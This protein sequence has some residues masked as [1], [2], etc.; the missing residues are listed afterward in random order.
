MVITRTPLR[1]SFVGGGTDLPDYYR[2]AGGAVLN[3]TIDQYLYVTVKTHSPLFEEGIRLNYSE[4]ER[5]ERVDQLKHP[6]AREILRLFEMTRN[7]Y[8]STVADLPGSS[9]LG[10]SSSFTVGLLQALHALLGRHPT[11]QQLAE[12]A[13]RIEIEILGRPIGKQDHYAAAFGGLNLFQFQPDGRTE[14]MPIALEPWKRSLLFDHLLFFHTGFSRDAGS[15]LSEQQARIEERRGV[16][17]SMRGQVFELRR[18]LEEGLELEAFGRLLDQ[19]W[20]MK[21][22]LASSVSNGAIDDW[23]QRGLKGGAYG[24]KL[25]GAGGGGF[26]M[27]VVPPHNRDRVR[28]ALSELV[29]VPVGFCPDG[30]QIIFSV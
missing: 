16:L 24:G 1:I 25:L 21:Q 23:Y 13:A 22:T 5:V 9:G 18:M 2:R 11:P 7:L 14:V 19:G 29:E 26:L 28:A 20:R 8:I 4:S 15:I 30:S 12:E 17:A 3:A 27:F 10:S 6:I